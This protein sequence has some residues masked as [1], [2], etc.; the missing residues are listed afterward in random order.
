M[1]LG[2]SSC[3]AR[4]VGRKTD[5]MNQEK[6]SGALLYNEWC[7]VVQCEHMTVFCHCTSKATCQVICKQ[8]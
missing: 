5:F 3:Q 6:V 1:L 8:P 4:L 7:C 2:R